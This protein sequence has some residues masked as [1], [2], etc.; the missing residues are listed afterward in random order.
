M[1]LLS[2]C[3]KSDVSTERPG[4]GARAGQAVQARGRRRGQVRTHT[5]VD[6]DSIQALNQTRHDIK[7]CHLSSVP[8][9]MWSDPP[10]GF[11]RKIRRTCG[12]ASLLKR[13]GPLCVGAGITST[14]PSLR[15]CS[16]PPILT[17]LNAS[18]GAPHTSLA[19]SRVGIFLLGP[20]TLDADDH[21]SC[22]F[23]VLQVAS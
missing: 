21:E 10:S 17:S 15:C 18:S 8:D 9:V 20:H 13:C 1:Q 5:L 2:C 7:V 23:C 3:C 14:C 22:G 4:G 16:S 12:G 11:D 6:I 19:L